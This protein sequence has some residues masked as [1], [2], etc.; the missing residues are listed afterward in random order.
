MCQILKKLQGVKSRPVSKSFDNFD[1]I[2][3]VLDEV[4]KILEENNN[5][6]ITARN[7]QRLNEAIQVLNKK[8][9]NY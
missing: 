7:R 5:V 3:S 4:S 8:V 6:V 1:K 2:P 9:R